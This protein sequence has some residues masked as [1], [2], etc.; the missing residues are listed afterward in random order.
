MS[1]F[2]TGVRRVHV[3]TCIGVASA[4][5]AIG[6]VAPALAT[7]VDVY[8]PV[9]TGRGSPGE[10]VVTGDRNAN[11][12]VVGWSKERRALIVE[13]RRR[14]DSERCDRLAAKRVSCPFDYEALVLDGLKGSDRI[15]VRRRTTRF[16]TIFAEGGPGSDVVLGSD[17]HDFITG[18]LGNDR[19]LGRGDFDSLNG[20]KLLPGGR[21]GRDVVRG[22]AGG[23]FVSDSADRGR[24]SLYGERGDDSVYADDGDAD[25]IIDGGRGDDT[26][27]LDGNDPKPVS[28][29]RSR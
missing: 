18:G 5:L 12:I 2:S 26:C 7:T 15:V 6:T 11:R 29:E 3:A 16:D 22:G 9:T 17:G 24:D 8:D 28:C 25:R 13:D 14:I 4:L 23:D 21:G 27:R 10:I 20:D 1:W 19:L